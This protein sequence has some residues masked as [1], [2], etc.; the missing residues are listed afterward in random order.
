MKTKGGPNWVCHRGIEARRGYTPVTT[1]RMR[2]RV[3]QGIEAPRG[4]CDGAAKLGAEVLGY[5]HPG[6]LGKEAAND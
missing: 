2:S 6:V 3:R 5:P 1:G 4:A